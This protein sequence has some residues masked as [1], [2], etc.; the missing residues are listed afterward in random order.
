MCFV[1]E[2]FLRHFWNILWDIFWTSLSIPHRVSAQSA[3]HRGYCLN[4]FEILFWIFL[5]FYFLFWQIIN[6]IQPI[7][8]NYCNTMNILMFYLHVIIL[9]ASDIWILCMLF[10]RLFAKMRTVD[11]RVGEFSKNIKNDLPLLTCIL[12]GIFSE[13]IWR[14]WGG[15]GGLLSN[16]LG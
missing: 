16:H 15:R 9:F 5:R 4:I 10:H 2:Y 12:S 7:I 1:F 8:S 3:A 14:K 6:K 13:T 11:K